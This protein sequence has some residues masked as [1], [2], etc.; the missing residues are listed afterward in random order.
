M[1]HSVCN[2]TVGFMFK[3]NGYYVPNKAAQDLNFNS[4]GALTIG[5]RVNDDERF[6]AVRQPVKA[7]SQG[8]ETI[9]NNKL[10]PSRSSLEAGGSPEGVFKKPVNV[11][12]GDVRENGIMVDD[13]QKS[14]CVTATPQAGTW[15]I[16]TG[17]AVVHLLSRL[18]SAS[19]K[20]ASIR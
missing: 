8:L 3:G 18:T 6:Y 20:T 15:A 9:M 5:S 12:V 7:E 11:A 4:D 10:T 2:I 19:S 1:K 16:F 13:S 17:I 14:T